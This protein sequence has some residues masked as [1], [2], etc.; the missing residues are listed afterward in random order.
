MLELKTI[1][2]RYIA[3]RSTLEKSSWHVKPVGMTLNI[4]SF[5]M[6]SLVLSS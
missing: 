1:H 6:L 5:L 2:Y 3:K 4:F